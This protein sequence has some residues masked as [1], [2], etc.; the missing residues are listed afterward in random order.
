MKKPLLHVFGTLLFVVA[1]VIVA[2][3]LVF[4]LPDAT[5]LWSVPVFLAGMGLHIIGFFEKD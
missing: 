5:T 3:G 1:L 4:K 2:V